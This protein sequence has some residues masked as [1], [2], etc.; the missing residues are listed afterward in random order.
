MFNKLFHKEKINFKNNFHELKSIMNNF[1]NFWTSIRKELFLRLNKSMR[2]I[3]VKWLILE[4]RS[5]KP[6]K[7]LNRWKKISLNLG[8][9]LSSLLKNINTDLLSRP[10]LKSIKLT[11]I[12]LLNLQILNC[13]KLEWENLILSTVIQLVKLY[14]KASKWNGRTNK[15]KKN[16]QFNYK[17]KNQTWGSILNKATFLKIQYNALKKMKSL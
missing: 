5:N 10:T 12:S 1:I 7:R 17:N 2:K 13:L 15:N 16:L 14:K 3:T 6:S 11:K 9:I 8:M 4:R